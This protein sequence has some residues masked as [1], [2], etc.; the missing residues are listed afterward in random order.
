MA[1]LHAIREGAKQQRTICPEAYALTANEIANLERFNQI[2]ALFFNTHTEFTGSTLESG[3]DGG[4]LFCI[5]DD[6][7][8]ALLRDTFKSKRFSLA[9]AVKVANRV[10]GGKWFYVQR[11]IVDDTS[12]GIYG[13]ETSASG[14]TWPIMAEDYP[15]FD[16][17]WDEYR[18]NNAEA[19]RQALR[20]DEGY[21]YASAHA[22]ADL[23]RIKQIAEYS[24][25]PFTVPVQEGYIAF[26]STPQTTALTRIGKAALDA[27]RYDDSVSANLISA[28]S[29]SVRVEGKPLSFDEAIACQQLQSI[30]FNKAVEAGFTTPDIEL[31]LDEF[32]RDRQLKD[33][34]E[35]LRQ[36]TEVAT[37]YY[38]LSYEFI[39][40]DSNGNVQGRYFLRAL[41]REAQIIKG[42]GIPAKA[43]FGFGIRF[44]NDM[45]N[46]RSMGYYPKGALALK[47]NAYKIGADV[48]DDIRRNLGKANR[49][50]RI[51]IATLLQATSLPS[52]DSI[53][54]KYYRRQIMEPFLSA[55]SKAAKSEYWDFT[56][57]I[58]NADGVTEADMFEIRFNYPLFISC[59]VEARLN[60]EPEYYTQLRQRN[61]DRAEAKALAA[62]AKV[63]RDRDKVSAAAKRKASGKRKAK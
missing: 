30:L 23:Q 60:H 56:Y 25:K 45:A 5:Y 11:I 16:A 20:L 14:L 18:D 44:F 43:V 35:A 21:L 29:I 8:V 36:F 59:I 52:A 42:R 63:E 55:L 12:S 57:K 17:V 27:S 53:E 51:R 31:T 58:Y 47:G 15:E 39:S 62:A 24:C 40:K 9:N 22:I 6:T 28:G 50:G 1:T 10:L 41:E 38:R 61:H 7:S 54:P 34:K 32:M 37:T 3:A 19:L 48:W 4:G 49:E 2:V 26:K 33:R 46:N 13:F